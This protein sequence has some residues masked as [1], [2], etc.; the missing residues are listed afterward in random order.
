MFSKFIQKIK[1]MAKNR[2]VSNEETT[3]AP[4][5]TVEQTETTNEI[6]LT[7]ELTQDVLDKA[8]SIAKNGGKEWEEI[9][10][11]ERWDYIKQARN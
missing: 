1:Q 6:N 5:T 11:E 9:T 4:E 10:Q 7:P 3:Q 8:I 2:N